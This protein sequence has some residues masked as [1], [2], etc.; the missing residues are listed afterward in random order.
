MAVGPT[1]PGLAVDHSSVFIA[2]GT[3]AASVVPPP[4]WYIAPPRLLG[5]S[6]LP[7]MPGRFVSKIWQHNPTLDA[8]AVYRRVRR[9]EAFVP[10]AGQP[11]ATRCRVGSAGS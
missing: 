1:D 8:P 2:K 6:S 4:P 5:R 9:C 10:D 11:N 3:M 7:S